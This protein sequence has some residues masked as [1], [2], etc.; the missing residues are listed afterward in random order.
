MNFAG[1]DLSKLDLRF[2]NFKMANLSGANLSLANLSFCTL[3]RANLS[4]AKMDGANL[5]GVKMVLANLE[6]A[7]LRTCNFE[8]PCGS[9]ANLEGRNNVCLMQC[10][11]LITLVK[12]VSEITYILIYNWDNHG[13]LLEF[14]IIL[15][16]WLEKYRLRD[17]IHFY[18]YLKQSWHLWELKIIQLNW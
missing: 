10:V 16:Y 3:E 9:K 8:D 5:Q 15:L 18:F 6:G 1:A 13:Y 7:S 14:K 2:I 12:C 11:T 17:Y 4:G